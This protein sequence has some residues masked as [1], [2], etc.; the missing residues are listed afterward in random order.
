MAILTITLE[1]HREEDGTDLRM[2]V[3]QSVYDIY[4]LANIYTEA[5]TAMG[6][7]EEEII[8]FFKRLE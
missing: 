4:D 5:A 2:E 6:Y 8:D 1:N 7:S 3:S